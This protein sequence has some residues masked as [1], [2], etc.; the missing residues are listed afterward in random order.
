[1]RNSTAYASPQ[2][3]AMRNS[4]DHTSPQA[5]AR[6]GGI[7]YLVIVVTGLFAEMYVRSGLIVRFDPAAT[8]INVM[9]SE[10]LLRKAFAGEM[11]LLICD[12][13]LALVFYVLLK[14]INRNLALLAALFRMVHLT[15]YGVIGLSNITAMILLGSAK[16]QYLKA[17]QPQQLEVLAYLCFKLHGEGYDIALI[18]F[19]CH[20]L[21]VGY[22]IF[23]SGYI[24]RILGIGMTVTGLC[25]LTNSFVG[26]LAPGF[27]AMLL[28]W[29]VL[30]PIIAEGILG[31]W[32]TVKG[33]NIPKWKEKQA[34][35]A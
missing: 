21:L 20:C 35:E 16:Y 2:T 33:V 9:A 5:Y 4:A 15:I 24:P 11:V 7:L 12:V 25:Y 19:S 29:I 17:F 3:Y 28:P 10:S 6:V 13:V 32:L 34:V 14:P 18:L 31:L 30:P 26:I 8:A 1:M 22:L 27:Q 23:K